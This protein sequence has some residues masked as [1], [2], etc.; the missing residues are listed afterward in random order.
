MYSNWQLLH[1][2]W[3]VSMLT[4]K[5]SQSYTHYVTAKIHSRHHTF[6]IRPLESTIQIFWKAFFSLV[7]SSRIADTSRWPAPIAAYHTHTVTTNNT[8]PACLPLTI[9]NTK[10]GYIRDN[11]SPVFAFNTSTN[12]RLS[13]VEVLTTDTLVIIINIV[14]K[15]N[16]IL[17]I[18]LTKLINTKIRAKIQT[19]PNVKVNY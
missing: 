17:S 12:D 5:L 2:H 15:A 6:T 18:S 4:D 16:V 10:F 11:L 19:Q 9:L 8:L 3:P 14:H 13:L 7:P 1:T